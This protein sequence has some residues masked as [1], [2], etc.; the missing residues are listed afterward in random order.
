MHRIFVLI[1][2]T[3]C[4]TVGLCAEEGLRMYIGTYT[5]KQSKGIYLCDFDPATGKLGEAKLAAETPN[6]TFLALHP[7]GKYLY[8]ANEIGKFE[9]KDTGCI[10]AFAIDPAT[11]LLKLLNAQSSMGRGPCH[12]AV[13]PNGKHL[14]GAN[15][16]EGSI[17][18]IPI[19]EDGS[20]DTPTAG[21]KHSGQLGPNKGRQEKP[22]AHSTNFDPSGRLVF[23]ADLGLDQVYIYDLD[24]AK[25][26]LTPHTPPSAAA[27]PGAGP[28]HLAFHPN[29]RF[30]FVVNELSNTVASYRFDAE[31]GTLTEIQSIGTLPGDFSGRNTTAEVLVHPSGN[32]LYASNRGHDSIAIFKLDPETGKLTAAGY[33]SSGGKTPRNFNLT[34]DGRWLIAANQDT[35]NICVFGVDE[36]TGALAP[37][38]NNLSLEKPVRV[39]FTAR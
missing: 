26:T 8:S 4:V 38:E 1:A 3:F 10:S 14:V 37:T 18:A 7:N 5:G 21:I 11:G 23:A 29:K 2:I 32:F 13:A 39:L 22:H 31:K 33:Q 34:P 6:P 9:G 12:V 36:K 27:G 24:A 28:R 15:Y 17:C 19:K 16:G 20:L 35:N 30:A 25:G